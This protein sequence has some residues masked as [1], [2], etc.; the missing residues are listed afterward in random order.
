MLNKDTQQ[1]NDRVVLWTALL[2]L[3]VASLAYAG[4]TIYRANTTYVVHTE[5]IPPATITETT[6]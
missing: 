6:R 4:F 5:V 1:A 2:I 3:L